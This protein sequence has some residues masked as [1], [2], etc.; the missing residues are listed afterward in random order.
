[1]SK[2]KLTQ[3][4]AE[5]Q[6]I[7]N[8]S[9]QKPTGLAKTKLVGVG[10]N[11]QENI[12][13]GDNLTLANGKLAA[14][15]AGGGVNGL[16][17]DA[18]GNLT[19][20]KN[21]GVDGKLTLKSLVS[22]SNPDGD[23]TKELGGGGSSKIAVIG[24]NSDWTGGGTD[25]A[26]HWSYNGRALLPSTAYEVGDNFTVEFTKAFNNQILQENQI[27]VPYSPK[28][29]LAYTNYKLKYGD[30]VLVLTNSNITLQCSSRDNENYSVFAT[31]YL[32]YSVVKAGT[33][34]ADVSLPS[35]GWNCSY[36]YIIYTL[37]TSAQ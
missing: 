29:S 26:A 3:T 25:P 30:V 9:L 28:T 20:G 17:S 19:V 13:I 15:A 22:E 23:I 14:A 7:L 37:G 36:S 32:T 11:G 6:D 1:M 16:Q 21:L 24:T 12:E 10:V 27:I 2:F 18:E 34:G 31:V 5:V 8:N 33:T 35:S 4:A